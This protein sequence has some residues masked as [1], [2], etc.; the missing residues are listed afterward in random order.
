MTTSISSTLD[1]SEAHGSSERE[2][3]PRESLGSVISGWSA[4]NRMSMVNIFPAFKW[5]RDLPDLY[6][7]KDMEHDCFPDGYGLHG[8]V[9]RPSVFSSPKH[10]VKL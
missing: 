2:N 6:G 9:T 3:V 10:E 5:Q 8:S 4:K 7:P 1:L